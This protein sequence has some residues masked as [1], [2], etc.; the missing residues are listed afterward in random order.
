VDVDHVLDRFR[1][2][3]LRLEDLVHHDAERRGRGEIGMFG[4]AG[5]AKA[6]RPN[7]KPKTGAEPG[8]R[9]AAAHRSSSVNRDG[10]NLVDA[11]RTP[12]PPG[13]A[14]ERRPHFDLFRKASLGPFT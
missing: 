7:P 11:A 4:T 12:I 13:C 2:L 8:A 3:F 10:R 14:G 6:G 1:V 9:V 5:D